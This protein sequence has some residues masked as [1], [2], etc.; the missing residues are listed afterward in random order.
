MIG[1]GD[2]WKCLRLGTVGLVTTGTHQC[3]IKLRRSNRCRILGVVGK[4]SMASLTRNHH[5][6]TQFFLVYDLG[7]ASL[8]DLMSR[9]SNRTR[10]DLGDSVS[11]IVAVLSKATGD[12]SGANKDESDRRNGHDQ[13]QPNEMFYVPK[14]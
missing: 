6:L 5:M 4:C 14:H 3:R 7:V 13:R 1:R 9:K 2:L 11:A 12:Y 8:A 10:R